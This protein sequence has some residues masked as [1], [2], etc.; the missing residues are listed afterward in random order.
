ME[1]SKGRTDNLARSSSSYAAVLES[2]LK[3]ANWFTAAGIIQ[4]LRRVLK[5]LNHDYDEDLVQVFLSSVNTCISNV[6]WD[7]FDVVVGQIGDAPKRSS[8]DSLSQKDFVGQSLK[9]VFLGN[10]VQFLCS[11]VE[12]S[13]F[14][15]ASDDTSER[16]LLVSTINLVPKLLRW[17]LGKHEE[18]FN[19]CL[20]RYFQYKLLV[21][22]HPLQFA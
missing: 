16:P 6:P 9:V 12:Q 2:K 15:D 13:R 1:C 3:D 18:C 7:C 5:S 22:D 14:L 19:A 17:C 10:L 21:R 20:S 4:V 8:A 11:L